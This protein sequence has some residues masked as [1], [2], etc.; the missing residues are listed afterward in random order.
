MP[1][2]NRRRDAASNA[3]SREERTQ[4]FSRTKMCKFHILGV[5]TK[6]EDCHFA[7]IRDDLELLPD[8]YRTKLCKT[9]IN[10]GK[11]DDPNCQY[12][13]NKEEMRC[14]PGFNYSMKEMSEKPPSGKIPPEAIPRKQ[15][16]DPV[17]QAAHNLVPP[18]R[19]V[20]QRSRNMAQQQHLQQ[21]PAPASVPQPHAFAMAGLP[22]GGIWAPFFTD[23]QGQ[24][25][26]P[27]QVA[28]LQQM[29]MDLVSQA[30][31]MQLGQA[32]Y[33]RQAAVLQMG[34]AAQAHA[35]EALRLQAMASRLQQN[36][37]A[38]THTG[39]EAALRGAAYQQPAKG[40]GASPGGGKA[41]RNQGSS[42][43][44][45]KVKGFDGAGVHTGV[46]VKNTF[47]TVDDDANSPNGNLRPVKTCGG[48]LDSL[49][50]A[51]ADDVDA[52]DTEAPVRGLYKFNM[53][54]PM[55][56]NPGSLKSLSS[57]SLT[58]MDQPTPER[59]DDNT[60][61]GFHTEGRSGDA[62]VSYKVKNTFIDVG[63]PYGTPMGMRSIHSAAGRLDAL[64]DPGYT[65]D[66]LPED[67][68]MFLRQETTESQIN[69]E[70]TDTVVSHRSQDAALAADDTCAF[71]TSNIDVSDTQPQIVEARPT[72]AYSRKVGRDRLFSDTP[73]LRVQ[74]LHVKNTFLDIESEEKAAPKL[75]AVHTA[76][77]RLDLMGL[78][79][80]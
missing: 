28:A 32:T 12:A 3:A 26:A 19:P 79:E 62:G 27:M 51:M 52:D 80:D 21:S 22:P 77:G 76:G 44:H 48:R 46:A 1:R 72:D 43:N 29:G 35:A 58:A 13:H 61:D 36:N 38:Q 59:E 30:A 20:A 23:Q 34:Q 2:R 60:A 57:N 56:I 8:L 24:G 18:E 39:G 73:G 11:C 14:V 71:P 50:A 33:E 15:H 42:A 69:G 45:G 40:S 31:A 78:G 7:H 25:V 74:G 55:Q 16:N 47:V 67:R 54:D 70:P 4:V 68:G 75:R 65:L 53:N 6:G 66:T 64:G 63:S 5:C 10:T 41:S 49:V 9:L 17:V 37:G